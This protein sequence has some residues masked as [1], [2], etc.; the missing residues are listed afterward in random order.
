MLVGIGWLEWV[1]LF[2]KVNQ[3]SNPHP[4]DVAA[5]MDAIGGLTSNGVVMMLNDLSNGS[6]GND[7]MS[8]CNVQKAHMLASSMTIKEAT[9]PLMLERSSKKN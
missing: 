8:G 6:H 1:L 9:G 7:G 5:P 4:T 3:G 2:E